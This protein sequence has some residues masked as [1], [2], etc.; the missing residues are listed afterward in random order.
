MREPWSLLGMR[1]NREPDAVEPQVFPWWRALSTFIAACKTCPARFTQL[2]HLKHHTRLH[3]NDRPFTCTTCGKRY[4]NA[5]GLRTHWKQT[6]CSS[7]SDV[8]NHVDT[9]LVDSLSSRSSSPC[10]NVPEDSRGCFSRYSAEK[11]PVHLSEEASSAALFEPS[12]RAR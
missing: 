10:T 12:N 3:T 1:M 4:T 9:R 6:N 5:S 8:R 7:F 11:M 2:V